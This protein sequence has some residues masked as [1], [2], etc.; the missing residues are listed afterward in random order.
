MVKA[1]GWNLKDAGSSPAHC[2]SFP[3][4]RLLLREF[5]IYLFIT[6][7]NSTDRYIQPSHSRPTEHTTPPP[8]YIA[9]INNS[10]V[11]QITCTALY[12]RLELLNTPYTPRRPPM[13]PY[14]T[15][16]PSG[17]EYLHS[18]PAPQYTPD[19]PMVPG[20]PNGPHHPLHP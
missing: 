15:Y 11:T 18:L 14:A 6:Y 3:C 10:Q 1:L 13:P 16:T 12:K 19:T 8:E 4:V 7:S 9:S 20:A 17:P 2:Y 5:I